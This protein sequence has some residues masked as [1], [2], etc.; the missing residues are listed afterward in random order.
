MEKTN[1]IY[2]GAINLKPQKN[3]RRGATVG[4][5]KLYEAQYDTEDKAKLSKL[6]VF[7]GFIIINKEQAAQA[8]VKGND[9]KEKLFF[10]VAIWEAQIATQ[11][12]PTSA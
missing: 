7:N 1:P 3:E 12:Q 10:Q 6:P 4:A 9:G 5:L 8:T 2:S 11:E